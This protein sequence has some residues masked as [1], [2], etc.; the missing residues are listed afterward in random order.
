MSAL[1]ATEQTL[2]SDYNQAHFGTPNQSPF[3]ILKRPRILVIAPTKM[4]MKR[5]P[6]GKSTLHGISAKSDERIRVNKEREIAA[7]AV[8]KARFN[9]QIA[10]PDESRRTQ[11][12]K[13]RV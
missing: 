9:V 3:D 2:M 7:L 13:G 1:C 6:K 12:I 4:P 5:G 11:S 8:K 10:S